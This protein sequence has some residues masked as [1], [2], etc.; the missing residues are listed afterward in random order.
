MGTPTVN[1]I[2]DILDVRDIGFKGRDTAGRWK[3]ASKDYHSRRDRHDALVD[4]HNAIKREVTDTEAMCSTKLGSC[5][6]TLAAARKKLRDVESNLNK[7]DNPY[8]C[9][10]AAKNAFGRK[11]RTDDTLMDRAQNE[12]GLAKSTARSTST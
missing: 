4:N 12:I 11:N 1:P 10:E 7:V 9:K 3:H 8:G 5:H 2:K 6:R